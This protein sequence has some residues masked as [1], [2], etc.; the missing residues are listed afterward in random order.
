MCTIFSLLA[1]NT[2]YLKTSISIMQAYILLA[3]E[4]F[5]KV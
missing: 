4:E 2:E 1:S 5:L 3:P